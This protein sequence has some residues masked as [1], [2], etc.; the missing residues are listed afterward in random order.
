MPSIAN[1]KP[2]QKI[3]IYGYGEYGKILECLIYQNTQATLVSIIDDNKIGQNSTFHKITIENFEQFLAKYDS[4]IIV[5]MGAIDADITCA[6][7]E[8][9]QKHGIEF[10]CIDEL[11]G[12]IPLIHLFTNDDLNTNQAKIDKC[13][14]MFDREVDKELYRFL[15]NFRIVDNFYFKKTDSSFVREWARQYSDFIN[16]KNISVYL[17]GGLFEGYT[18]SL[19]IKNLFNDNQNIHIYGF[20]PLKDIFE[21]SHFKTNIES[22]CKF[23]PIYKALWNK[24]TTLNFCV[25]GTASKILENSNADV[26]VETISIDE[27][28]KENK[29][30]KVDFIKLDIE[31]AEIEAIA[32]AAMTIARDRPQLAISI[33]HKKEHLYEIPL[34]LNEMCK[35]Y[36]FRL[37]R[38]DLNIAETILYA[39]PKEINIVEC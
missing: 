3:A 30:Y 8:K 23:T 22:S 35:D 19:M 1:I 39:I 5:I 15:I 27:F 13:V 25:Q 11:S 9:L 6:I 21:N 36:N 26:K 34:L 17:D 38:Y 32:G 24:K 33:Y 2:G 4:N 20:E 29:I 12:Y 31:G 14:N 7:S 16:P 10:L 18:T 37:G 28:V